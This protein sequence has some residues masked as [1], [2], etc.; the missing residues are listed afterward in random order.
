MSR[1]L[2]IAAAALLAAG[3]GKP[4]DPSEIVNIFDRHSY[5]ECDLKKLETSLEKSGPAELSKF[6]S[7]A[8]YFPSTWQPGPAVAGLGKAGV[9]LTLWRSGE[10]AVVVGVFRGSPAE[11]AGMGVG[12]RILYIDDN[13]VADMSDADLAGVV[14]G[15][16][17]GA[18]KLKGS[19]RDGSSLQVTLKRTY[20][21]MP[22]VWGFNI[23]GT[24]TGYLRVISFS[25]KSS[26]WM[27]TAM[28]DM[29]D[30]GAKKVIIDLRG[31]RGGSLA[32][33]STALGYFAPQSCTLF[34]TVSRHAG[35][36][37]VFYSH[38]QGSYAG[39]K[40]VLLTDAATIS[41]A[42]IF[43]AAMREWKTG[44]IVGARTAG[45]VSTTRGFRLNTG[46][47]MRLTVARLVP[48]SGEEID[49]QG[50]LPDV[51]V[52]APAADPGV[53][54]EFPPAVASSDPV[55]KKALQQ[56]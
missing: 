54:V 47:A 26:G 12:D 30:N 18:C 44:I 32:E 21:G 42:E 24:Q 50:L 29:L 7:H 1:R 14:Y 6:D 43:A 27:R 40:A 56:P 25:N 35:Y 45:N 23:P 38:G 52:D 20:G 49:G 34:S 19:A 11:K 13:P 39:I 2:I 8:M 3:C 51:A 28:N 55:L 33:L 22:I 53:I 41:R 15:S 9:G 17:G 10:A 16:T 31:N 46:G 4:V 36:S 5:A 37:R 48:P